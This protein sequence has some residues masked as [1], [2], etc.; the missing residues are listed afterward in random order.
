MSGEWAISRFGSG[1][2]LM[3]C[4]LAV[5]RG[6]PVEALKF[7]V[8]GNFQALRD[9]VN[10]HDDAAFMWSEDMS[11]PYY[12][13]GEIKRIGEITTPWPSFLVCSLSSYAIN[14]EKELRALSA[15]LQEACELFRSTKDIHID[16]AQLHEH[17]I[18]DTK[19]WYDAV[20]IT[21]SNN[22]A[23]S[24]ITKAIAALIEAKQL[25]PTFK[26][27]PSQY[28]A[29]N[30]AQ[31]TSDI[32]RMRLYAR[33]ELLAALHANL[34]HAKLNIGDISYKQLL[35]YDQNSYYRT[36]KLDEYVQLCRLA[37][38]TST[39]RIIQ[40]GSSVGGPSRYLAGTYSNISV[41]AIE[42]QHDLH[43]AAVELTSR[44]V[45]QSV[46]DNIHYMAADYLAVAPHLQRESFDSISSWLT[47]LHF[48]QQQRNRLFKVSYDLLKPG[49]GDSIST[50][51][52]EDF[53][54]LHPLNKQEQYL[55]R[56]EV[57][58]NYL[59]TVEQYKADLLAAGYRSVEAFDLTEKWRIY[60]QQRADDMREHRSEREAIMGKDVVAGLLH[61]YD[62]VAELYRGGNL[63]GVRIIAVK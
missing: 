44:C 60:T 51:F 54:Q 55:L 45:E 32:K 40:F 10:A 41:L 23:E 49:S 7:Y 20:S 4:V 52:V 22:I 50:F 58:C 37:P 39:K 11:Q 33:P 63:G 46:R 6:W 42:L 59:S 15:A 19:R 47:V 56:N 25:P 18:D 29:T 31:L 48:D 43:D 36:E 53:C 1:S 17:T 30:I 28:I 35:P 27:L 3:T 21:G 9:Y 12:D 8:A 62:A 61:F 34:R 2:H 16:I 57:Y 24:T 38:S 14:H 13:S 26:A 5:G